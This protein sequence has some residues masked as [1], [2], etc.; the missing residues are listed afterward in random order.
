MEQRCWANFG[1]MWWEKNKDISKSSVMQSLLDENSLNSKQYLVDVVV[2][3]ELL[4]LEQRE[5]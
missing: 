4:G 5:C 3:L 1:H 2:V